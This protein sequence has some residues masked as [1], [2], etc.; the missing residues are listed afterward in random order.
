MHQGQPQ[1]QPAG[2]PRRHQRDGARRLY[3][4]RARPGEAMLRRL[5]GGG[6]GLMSELLLEILSEEI[7]A[8]MQARAAEDLARLL[9]EALKPAGLSLDG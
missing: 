7:P 3:R 8:R 6:G 5:A 4:P 2:R 1:L 9:G